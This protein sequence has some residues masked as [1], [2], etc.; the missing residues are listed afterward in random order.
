MSVH[1]EVITT[2]PPEYVDEVTN[3]VREEISA[4]TKT[5]PLLSMKWNQDVGSWYGCKAGEGGEQMGWS[6]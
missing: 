3:A 1:D 6:P 5:I 2:T 4:L